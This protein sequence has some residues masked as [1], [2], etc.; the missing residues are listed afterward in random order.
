VANRLAPLEPRKRKIPIPG[1]IQ[2]AF[3]RRN[4]GA[5]RIQGV[6]N[7]MIRFARCCQP[8]PGDPIKGIVTIGRGVSVHREDCNSL[9]DP[10]VGR[11]RLIDVTWDVDET[12]TF[13]VQVTVAGHDRVN[14]LADI[15]RAIG[16]FDCNIQSG[17][18]EGQHEYA[19]CSFIVEVRNLNHLQKILAAIRRLPG[20]M[21]VHRAVFSRD[22]E[23]IEMEPDS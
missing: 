4:Q 14:L 21:R 20:V 6:D 22:D 7:L 11:E 5:V 9:S 3:Q 19:L 23:V 1:R 12:T 2:K 17:T 15:S 10:N 13:P 16:E 18:F 8:V